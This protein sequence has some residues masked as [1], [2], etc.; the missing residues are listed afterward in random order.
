MCT[1]SIPTDNSAQLA[2]QQAAQRQ[3]QISQGQSAI[4]SAFGQFDD[5]YFKKYGDAYVANYDPQVDQQYG[6]AKQK[7]RY[8]VARR[9]MLDSQDA[10]HLNDNLNRGYSE[11][12]QQVA[13]NAVGAQ[14]DLRNNVAQQ[15][16]QLY[17]L[18]SSAADPTLAASSAA[19][20]AGTIPSTPQ[21]S[22]LGD[23]FSGLVNA[24]SGYVAGQA[25]N[26]P[27]IPGSVVGGTLPSSGSGRVVR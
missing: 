3:Q 26:N 19:A 4:D 14:N 23:L 10:I 27:Y 24:G 7:L 8:N 13:S 5:N 20:A 11:Q 9:G 22:T 25:R 18:N 16:S 15:K 2:A 6:D 17:A 1:P 12:R 21:Y